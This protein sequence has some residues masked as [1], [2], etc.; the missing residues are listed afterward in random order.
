MQKEL[1]VIINYLIRKEL[2]CFAVFAI[3]HSLQ[4]MQHLKSYDIFLTCH[5]KL[6]PNLSKC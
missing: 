1:E 6:E 2:Y 4:L 3:D 5:A